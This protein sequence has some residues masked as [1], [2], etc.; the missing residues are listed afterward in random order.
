MLPLG[1]RRRWTDRRHRYG[2]YRVAIWATLV[3]V[4][5]LGVAGFLYAGYLILGSF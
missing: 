3:T 5:W 4:S 1:L 2:L